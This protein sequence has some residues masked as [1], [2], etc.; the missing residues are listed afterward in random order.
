MNWIESKALFG[1]EYWQKQ[2]SQQLYSYVNRL[3]PGCVIY[4]FGFDSNVLNDESITLL[5]SFPKEVYTMNDVL[6]SLVCNKQKHK[7]TTS[8]HTPA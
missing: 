7:Y 8:S 6:P 2:N 1:D 5:S 3:G 4:W